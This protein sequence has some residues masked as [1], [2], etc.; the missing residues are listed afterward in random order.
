LQI[1]IGPK[2]QARLARLNNEHGKCI[3]CGA[4]AYNYLIANSVY[5]TLEE[6]LSLGQRFAERIEHIL[7][8]RGVPSPKVKLGVVEIVRLDFLEFKL[9]GSDL[10]PPLVARWHIELLSFLLEKFGGVFSNSHSHVVIATC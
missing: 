9:Y 4:R 7:W 6:W 1:V 2:D 5:L 10:E 8:E 3:Y